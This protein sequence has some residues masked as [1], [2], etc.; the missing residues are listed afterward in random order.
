MQSIR[1]SYKESL[2]HVRR[3][4]EAFLA[5]HLIPLHKIPGLCPIGLG[6]IHR[7]IAGKVFIAAGR[8]D[9]ISSVGSLKICAGHEAG[10]ETV[11]HPMNSIF[12]ENETEAILLVDAANAYNSINLKVILHKINIICPSIVT[13][14]YKCYSLPSR[15]IIFGV[16]NRLLF[17]KSLLI[18]SSNLTG[19]EYLATVTTPVGVNN[20]ILG[21]Q[22]VRSKCKQNVKLS[23]KSW[24][25][26]IVKTV[27]NIF[28]FVKLDVMTI[29]YPVF[30]YFL[31]VRSTNIYLNI[32]SCTKEKQN[33]IY[34][35]KECC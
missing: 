6:K 12:H 10:C 21:T 30:D 2:L 13:L 15:L 3:T 5:C 7:Q 25:E 34:G 4:L 18:K 35:T 16:A 26:K 9:V 31:E 1:R 27:P 20:F 8:N 17:E 32:N 33:I 22:N 29:E 19:W 14:V 11:A 28:R 23:I 24:T